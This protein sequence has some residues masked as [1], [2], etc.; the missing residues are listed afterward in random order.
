MVE[1]FGREGALPSDL[2]VVAGEARDLE[3]ADVILSG[4][5]LSVQSLALHK[6]KLEDTGL[7]TYAGN[8][9]FLI[10]M[11]IALLAAFIGYEL[12]DHYCPEV[13]DSTGAKVG[14]AIGVLLYVLGGV[15]LF[16]GAAVLVIA[17]D[18]AFKQNQLWAAPIVYT[19]TGQFPE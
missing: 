14:C 4:S 8:A 18:K 13:G 11:G 5:I 17:L 15:V 10:V 2:D 12:V 16:L 3:I 1:Q 19:D 7:A 9:P 6:R